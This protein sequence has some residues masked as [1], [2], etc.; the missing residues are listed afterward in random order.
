MLLPQPNA[1]CLSA[2]ALPVVV[3]AILA[4]LL[5][6]PVQA[7]TNQ[8]SFSPSSLSFGN[9]AV[10]KSTTFQA[11]LTNHGKTNI[12]ITAVSSSDSQFKASSLNL[13]MALGPGVGLEINVTYSPTTNGAAS[14]TISVTNNAGSPATLGLSGT[15]TGGET[16]TATPTSLAFGNVAVGSSSTLS[17]V[18]KNTGTSSATLTSLTV[19]GKAFSVTGAKFPYTLAAGKTLTLNATFSPTVAGAAS[20]S[21]VIAGP[22]LTIPLSGTG[23]TSS[24]PLLTVTPTTLAFGNVATGT[25]STLT[26]GLT[27]TG[28]GVTVTSVSSSNSQFA[29]STSF[30]LTVTVGKEVFVNVTF[31]P[32]N[33]GAA[34]GTLTFHSNASNSTLT[35]S[36]S[37]TGTAPYVSLSWIASTSPHI[38]GYNV[39]R[40][41]S[42]SGPYTKLNSKLDADTSY[43]DST[44]IA[45]TY[46][47]VTT[48]VNSSGQESSYSAQVKVVVP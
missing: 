30:P 24:K 4:T 21:A 39:Y 9:V 45:G 37:G 6:T 33:N 2:A 12:T 40:T 1:R 5:A 35:E 28:A 3:L 47:Y 31:T 25:T 20:G 19:T 14:G 18:L 43:T 17:V 23:T 7:A 8:L 32:K 27:A 44:V 48:A 34:S 26:A 15:G 16:V 10:G 22:G 38:T 11:N 29:V 42:K 41:T 13:P 46:Y 36:L